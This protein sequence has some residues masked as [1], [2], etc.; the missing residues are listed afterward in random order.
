[1]IIYKPSGVIIKQHMR[2][3]CMIDLFKKAGAR[4]QYS[5]IIA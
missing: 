5:V 2:D 1:M 4:I 3:V